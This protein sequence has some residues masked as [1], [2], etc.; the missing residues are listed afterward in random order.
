MYSFEQA[1]A[2]AKQYLTN[3]GIWFVTLIEAKVEGQ[4]WVITYQDTVL[5]GTEKY[6][7]ELDKETGQILSYRRYK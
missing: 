5:F 4:K 3:Q 6:V 1:T 7:V 2:K